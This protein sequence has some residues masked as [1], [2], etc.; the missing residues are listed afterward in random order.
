MGVSGVLFWVRGAGWDILV[1][2]VWVGGALFWVSG[3]LSWM[4]RGRWGIILGGW[5]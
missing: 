1:G 2:W 3:V 5:G 4:G